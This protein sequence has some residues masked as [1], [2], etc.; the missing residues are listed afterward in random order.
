MSG[1]GEMTDFDLNKR[2]YEIT[3]LCWHNW[4][5]IFTKDKQW[6]FI[7]TKCKDSKKCIPDNIDFLSWAGFGILWEF[8]QEHEQYSE[9]ILIY[10]EQD[11]I[12]KTPKSGQ[13]EDYLRTEYISPSALAKAV[14]EF[15]EE[16]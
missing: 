3:G 2:L 5:T 15:F 7:C 8:I 9:F 6:F 12:Q 13:Y 4:D 11:F 14:V 10:G 16:D 1:G